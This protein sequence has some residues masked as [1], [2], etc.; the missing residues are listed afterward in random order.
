MGPLLSNLVITGS[1]LLKGL[2]FCLNVFGNIL[3]VFPLCLPGHNDHLFY[4]VELDFWI[5]Y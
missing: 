1:T 2:S 4:F 5:L 3:R